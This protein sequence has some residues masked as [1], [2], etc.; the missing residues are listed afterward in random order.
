MV[1]LRLR[2]DPHN[3][4]LFNH[5]VASGGRKK[6]PCNLGVNGHRLSFS[7]WTD[8]TELGSVELF[9]VVSQLAVSSCLRL[10]LHETNFVEEAA[11]WHQMG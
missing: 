7:A 1:E 11:L 9:V 4:R 3:S 5:H 2:L 6:F 8:L 10:T